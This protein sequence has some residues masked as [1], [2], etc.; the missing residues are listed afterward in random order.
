[1]TFSNLGVHWKGIQLEWRINHIVLPQDLLVSGY[2]P[3]IQSIFRGVCK[4]VEDTVPEAREVYWPEKRE[5][6]YSVNGDCF[7][8]VIPMMYSVRMVFEIDQP[9]SDTDALI[10]SMSRTTAQV[11]VDTM[12]IAIS[13]GLKDL[14]A[15]AW[16]QALRRTKN[17]NPNGPKSGLN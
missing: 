9:L 5:L 2:S 14:I 6:G 7:L 12:V 8:K 16:G 15:Q 11:K 1:L 4:T 13:S 17:I 10:E 3:I